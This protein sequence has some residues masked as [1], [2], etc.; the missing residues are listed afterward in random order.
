M[1]ESMRTDDALA[2]AFDNRL[3]PQRCIKIG[4]QPVGGSRG[5]P[6]AKEADALFGHCGVGLSSD[7]RASIH[8]SL[9]NHDLAFAMCTQVPR[10]DGTRTDTTVSAWPIEHVRWDRLY[11][12]FMTRIDPASGSPADYSINGE[13]V[14]SGGEVPII[15]GDGRWVIFQRFEV[16]P[17]KHATILAAALVWARHAYAIRDWAKGSVAHGSAKV[18]GEL[19]AG[20]ALQ[21]ADG[22]LTPEASAMADLMRGIATGDSLAGIKPAG[23]KIEFLTN[24]SSAWQV[25]NEL[26]A[27][28]EGAAARLYLGTDGTLGSKGGAPG[29][30]IASLFGVASTKVQGDLECISRGIQ[31]GVIEPWAAMNFGD[32][33]LAPQHRYLVPDDDAIALKRSLAERTAAFSAA[34]KGLVDARIPLTQEHVDGLADDFGVRAPLLPVAPVAEAASAPAAPAS[35]RAAS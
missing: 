19:P 29:V 11:N 14:F 2:T 33:S 7:T 31:T 20:V 15:H 9:V 34:L 35:L 30:D 13:A 5:V 16:D 23:S 26:V 17:F 28:A 21:D 6:I 25:W 24:N 1:A 27:N 10:A 12:C 32:S 18:V 3:A 4:L 8:S 22:N